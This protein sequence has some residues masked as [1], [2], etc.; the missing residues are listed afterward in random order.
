MGNTAALQ[1]V[2]RGVIPKRITRRGL[3]EEAQTHLI[4]EMCGRCNTIFGVGCDVP[5]GGETIMVSQILSQSQK[6]VVCT[7]E[8][9]GKGRE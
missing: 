2:A 9:M 3:F 1:D 7:F 8:E 6:I 5:V 4:R